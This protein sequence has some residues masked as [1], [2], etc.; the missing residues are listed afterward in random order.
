MGILYKYSCDIEYILTKG[1]KMSKPILINLPE[2]MIE[3]LDEK[4]S[5]IGVARTAI[6]KQIIHQS[7][8]NDSNC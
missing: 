7:L 5:K 1:D 4:A 8:Q 3:Q 6:I 2:E